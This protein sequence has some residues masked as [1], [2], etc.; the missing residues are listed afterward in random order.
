M[1]ITID[2][3]ETAGGKTTV[4]STRPETMHISGGSV[5]KDLLPRKEAV[6]AGNPREHQDVAS[7]LHPVSPPEVRHAKNPLRT[8]SAIERQLAERHGGVASSINAGPPAHRGGGRK[9]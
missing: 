5:R 2:I 9:K 7:A 1:R 6:P 4:V 3:E 8:G